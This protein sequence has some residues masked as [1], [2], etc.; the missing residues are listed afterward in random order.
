MSFIWEVSYR[1]ITM[2][3]LQL[4]VNT[5]TEGEALPAARSWQRKE[6][7][8]EKSINLYKQGLYYEVSMLQ[9]HRGNESSRFENLLQGCIELLDQLREHYQ[10]RVFDYQKLSDVLHRMA[11]HYDECVKLFAPAHLMFMC[12][13]HMQYTELRKILPYYVQVCYERP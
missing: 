6:S 1:V 13:M 7:L 4:H 3:R 12:Y 5:L 10:K 9:W 11:V 2:L 8:Y